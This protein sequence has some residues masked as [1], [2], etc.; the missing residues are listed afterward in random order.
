M[1]TIMLGFIGVQAQSIAAGNF[2]SL[3]ICKNPGIPKT[4]G[5]NDFGRLGD[6]TTIF[7]YTPVHAK[8]NDRFA[9]YLINLVES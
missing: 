2:H 6:G 1:L 9:A 3:Y 8:L 5:P 4:N 7:R